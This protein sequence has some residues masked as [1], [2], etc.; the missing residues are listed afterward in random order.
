MDTKDLLERLLAT[1]KEL[2]EQGKDAAQQG[3]DFAA[4]KL[5]IPEEPG[6][7]RDAAIARAKK[8]ALAGGLL[9]LL[10]TSKNGRKVIKVGSVAALGGLAYKVYSDWQKQKG[11][12]SSGEP[13]GQL[14]GPN[15]NERSR[16][17]IKAMIAA[18]KSDGHIDSL[19]QG[20]ISEN[21]QAAHLGD[22]ASALL[23]SEVQK[24]LD[25]S[26]IATLAASEET[27]VEIY[28]ASLM[29]VDQENEQERQYLS[30]L[31]GQLKL[32]QELREQLDSESLAT[33]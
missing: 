23:L 16:N 19:E 5:G 9:A 3:M 27:A 18:A 7:E 8:Y 31:A 15:A 22:E 1:G 13:L 30:D 17:I 25:V 10:G 21:I 28:L 12:E 24:P 26:E 2:A 11:M 4:E 20:R 32:S 33:T 6:P 29:I 14:S